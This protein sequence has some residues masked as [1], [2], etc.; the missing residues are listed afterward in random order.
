MI[1]LRL[2]G[3]STKMKRTVLI[4]EDEGLIAMD[5]EMSLEER[6]VLC[7]V[8]SSL[9]E[10]RAAIRTQTFDAAVL[11]WHLRM[12]D[13]SPIAKL[14][15]EANIPFVVCTGSG[16]AELPEVFQRVPLISKPF[17]SN[18]LVAALEASFRK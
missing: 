10:A 1:N 18:D 14:L 6:G 11:D 8:A 7:R 17:V 15:Q 16:V 5:M 2:S 3:R 9:D 13:T 12:V 4:V